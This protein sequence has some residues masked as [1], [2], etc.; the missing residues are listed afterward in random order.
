M[1]YLQTKYIKIYKN[2]SIFSSISDFHL[3]HKHDIVIDAATQYSM[4]SLVCEGS[5][6]PFP[7]GA[8]IF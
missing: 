4:P 7:I 8:V 1:V 3:R 5:T 2:Y 6:Q